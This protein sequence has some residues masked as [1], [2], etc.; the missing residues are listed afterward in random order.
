MQRT[1][2][3]VKPLVPA[4]NIFVITSDNQAASVRK[5]LPK[6]PKENVIAEP[7]GRNTCTAV[8]LGAALVGARTTTG[9]MAV[10]PSDHIIPIRDEE[11]YR[12]ILEEC[13]DL[14]S[15][16]GVIATI[17]IKPT[18]PETGYGYIHVGNK[19]PPPKDRKAYATD[20]HC[21]KNFIEK[22]KYHRALDYLQSGEYRWNAGMFIF[23]CPTI[24]RSL[25]T[26]QKTLHKAC[27]RWR[28]KATN[29][30]KLKLALK[31]D[32]LKLE[33]ISFDHGVMEKAENVVVA[34]GNF[35]WDDLGSWASLENHIKTDAEGNCVEPS[36]LVFLH[37]DA[38]RNIIFDT[39]KPKDRT[40]VTLVG[41]LDC[42][43]V[44]TDD[45][46]MIARKRDTQKVRELYQKVAEE[47]SSK[48]LA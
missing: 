16:G 9:V 40:P 29:Q 39:R 31:K 6:V 38:A 23:S 4:K 7:C 21:A 8:A 12:K 13:F 27:G 36:K 37:V 22:P 43:V 5:Q 19:L 26:H 44:Q 10:L 14:C 41:L 32:Y 20:F 30:A 25:E 34:D 33:S 18:K 11:K 45:V 24:N 28:D 42:V 15:Q 35:D 2:D 3:R 1:Y 48:H 46:L 17:G 47:K